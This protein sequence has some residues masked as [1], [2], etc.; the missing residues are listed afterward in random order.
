MEHI[1]DATQCRPKPF[2]VPDVADD[3][4]ELGETSLHFP[5]LLLVSA[6]DNNLAR[7][8][9]NKLRRN[10]EPERSCSSGDENPL[11]TQG[12]PLRRRG[13]Y[14]CCLRCHRL[15]SR[16]RVEGRESSRGPLPPPVLTENR[17]DS[18]A[19]DRVVEGFQRQGPI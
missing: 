4:A 3:V 11:P 17:F 5:L 12:P 16:E 1:I 8:L 7:R 13:R 10:A 14:S 19:E 9:L 2:D 6:V 15:H 18:R